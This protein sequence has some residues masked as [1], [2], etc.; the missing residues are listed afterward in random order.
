MKQMYTDTP[1]I[2][3]VES[4]RLFWLVIDKDVIGILL[5]FVEK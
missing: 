4:R 3:R 5:K 1:Q 2:I